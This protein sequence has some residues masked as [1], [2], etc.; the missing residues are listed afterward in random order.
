MAELTTLPKANP[1]K[2]TF[3]SSGNGTTFHFGG[4][5]YNLNARLEV[6]QIPYRSGVQATT[7]WVGAQID[8]MIEVIQSAAPQAKAGRIKSLAVST[9]LRNA[10]SGRWV[11]PDPTTYPAGSHAPGALHFGIDLVK[12]SDYITCL[13]PPVI[14]AAF[15]HGFGIPEQYSHNKRR[16][17]D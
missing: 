10:L 4:K 1:G 3:G 12:P 14:R 16:I 7:D 2:Y 11:L 15:T 8:M 6:V 17:S 13:M 9:A 5:I